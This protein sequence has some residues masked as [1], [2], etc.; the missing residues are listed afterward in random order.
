M[1][2]R[3]EDYHNLLD[4]S[5]VYRREPYMKAFSIVDRYLECF[6]KYY[7]LG[8]E[9]GEKIKDFIPSRIVYLGIGGS[10]IAGDFINI[11]TEEVPVIVHRDYMVFRSNP[12]DLIIAVSYSGDTAEIFPTLLK[13]LELNRRMIMITSDGRLR[14]LAEKMNF[15][16]IILE[17]GIPPR[18]AFPHTLGALL[19]LIQ[20]LGI[21]IET[22]SGSIVET[23]KIKENFVPETPTAKNLAKKSASK[24]VGMLPIVY[25]YGKAVPIAYRLKCQLNENSK[26]FSHFCEV[27]EAFHNDV[28]ILNEK[29]VLLAPR[30]SNEPNEIDEVYRALS[31]F[32][33]ENYIELKVTAGN[34]LSEILSLLIL[35]DYIS[36]Y[37]AILRNVDPLAL[38]VIPKLK[39]NNRNYQEILKNVDER[40]GKI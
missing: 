30:L 17:P 28:E 10:A 22:L 12:D 27:P 32:L 23:G 34:F 29:T 25:G 21:K 9:V 4:N 11:I 24:I 39:D 16:S 20:S 26:I 2:M 8:L 13:N 1:G 3:S 6:S 15:P 14:K 35:V 5:E 40:L 33:R 37:A 38:Y 31:S 18:Y 7:H 19:G 36:L